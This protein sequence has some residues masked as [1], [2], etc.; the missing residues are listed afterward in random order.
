MGILSIKNK[1]HKN[2]YLKEFISVI[3]VMFTFYSC[4]Q[5]YFGDYSIN[6]RKLYPFT[7]YIILLTC[8]SFSYFLSLN[9]NRPI[10]STVV[11]CIVTT[12]L[13][14]LINFKLRT[15]PEFHTFQS[16]HQVVHFLHQKIGLSTEQIRTKV[17]LVRFDNISNGCVPISTEEESD[18]GG[19][20]NI[21]KSIPATP[22]KRIG[23]K[24]YILLSKKDFGKECNLEVLKKIPQ[25]KDLKSAGEDSY[26]KAFSFTHENPCPTTLNN[27]YLVENISHSK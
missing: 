27:P 20:E 11:V 14:N 13:L 22:N 24:C 5:F 12:C 16:F 19:V 8:L 26:L 17:T 9:I 4:L 21:L 2:F 18:F 25:L 7:P 10:Y 3:L 23:A 15:I 1:L 6:I